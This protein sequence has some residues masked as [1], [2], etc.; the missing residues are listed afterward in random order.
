MGKLTRAGRR[1]SYRWL[2]VL[3]LLALLTTALVAVVSASS[4][5]TNDPRPP[6]PEGY[7][8]AGIVRLY[9]GYKDK[10]VFSSET[11]TTLGTQYLGEQSC[12]LKSLGPDTLLGFSAG[13]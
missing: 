6:P 2:S 4:S 7:D 5:A 8:A 12:V 13:A 10:V 3:G 11:G 1:G 9:T